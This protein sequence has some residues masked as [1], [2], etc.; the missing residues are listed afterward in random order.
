MMKLATH[1]GQSWSDI[2]VRI[3]LLARWSVAMARISPATMLDAGSDRSQKFCLSLIRMMI[4]NTTG[5]MVHFWVESRKRLEA[6]AKCGRLRNAR[7][8]APRATAYRRLMHRSLRVRQL[9]SCN[10]PLMI[11]FA[12]GA[13]PEP[14]FTRIQYIWDFVWPWLRYIGISPDSYTK[15]WSWHSLSSLVDFLT[16]QLLGLARIRTHEL[17]TSFLGFHSNVVVV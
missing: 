8:G 14:S 15:Y 13:L 7:S 5:V 16:I 1:A 6:S 11:M 4:R 12:E 9:A 3:P 17:F 2:Q 10:W